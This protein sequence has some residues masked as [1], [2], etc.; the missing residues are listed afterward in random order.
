MLA[1]EKLLI[2]ISL[3]KS[4]LDAGFALLEGFLLN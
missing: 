3:S 4:T 2:I 1:E